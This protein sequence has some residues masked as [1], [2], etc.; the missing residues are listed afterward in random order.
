MSGA[1]VIRKS[2]LLSLMAYT[3]A[4]IVLSQTLQDP[5]AV[6]TASLGD[7]YK[8]V[9]SSARSS[10][11]GAVEHQPAAA[12]PASGHSR[13]G[14]IISSSNNDKQLPPAAGDVYHSVHI[15]RSSST[16]ALQQ[17]AAGPGPG[18]DEPAAQQQQQQQQQQQL[19]TI[20]DVYQGIYSSGHDTAAR[21]QQQQLNPL[22][23]Q[24]GSNAQR[25]QATMSDAYQGAYSTSCHTA[26][27]E[28]QQQELMRP[29]GS[30]DASQQQHVTI[31]DVHQGTHAVSGSKPAWSAQQSGGAAS[32]Q[33]GQASHRQY[34]SVGNVHN[35]IYS[36]ASGSRSSTSHMRQASLNALSHQQ[37]QQQGVHEASSSS[38]SSS[39]R[40]PRRQAAPAGGSKGKV[41]PYP[42]LDIAEIG[43]M[44]NN[45][46]QKILMLMA[47]HEMT[48]SRDTTHPL[49]FW[50]LA[51]LHGMPWAWRGHT[52]SSYDGFCRHYS[53][54][55]GPW[56][57]PYALAFEQGLRR[58]GAAAVARLTN[59]TLRHEYSRLLPALRLP[60]WDWTAP[61]VPA[62]LIA[63]SV[64]IIDPA[65]QPLA[66]Y[67]PFR[68]YTFPAKLGDRGAIGSRDVDWP[69][70]VA[71]ASRS[72]ATQ[73][74]AFVASQDWN[75]TYMPWVGSSQQSNGCAGNL[76]QMHN[77]IHETI[78]GLTGEMAIL[79]YG[80]FDPLF[81]LHHAMIDRALWLYQ[82]NKGGWQV[83]ANG[84]FSGYFSPFRNI[85]GNYESL[86]ATA[87][88]Y[89]DPVYL[90]TAAQPALPVS[91]SSSGSSGAFP[92]AADAGTEVDSAAA[93]AAVQRQLAAWSGG[94]KGYTW[95]LQLRQFRPTLAGLNQT[96]DVFVFIDGV[97]GAERF[98]SS[99]SSS[100]SRIRPNTLRL[101]KDYCGSATTWKGA[102]AMLAGKRFSLSVDLT[103]CMRAAGISADVA[104]AD[105][106]NAAKGPARAPIR[107]SDLRFMVL[108]AS[109]QDL[110]ADVNLGKPVIGWALAVDAGRQQ[111]LE[112]AS[113]QV[114]SAVDAIESAP[115]ALNDGVYSLHQGVFE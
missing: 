31:G 47:W 9:Y 85:T 79:K 21:Q 78:G 36:G 80:G 90:Q 54:A 11:N 84:D 55:F 49:S 69:A 103:S 24:G 106:S 57:R 50:A 14:A 107:V 87:Y 99:S 89:K 33:V 1:R 53:P 94:H 58:A 71:R 75:C 52:P 18:K 19:A 66:V 64:T 105:A 22:Q 45:S 98:P 63:D 3:L 111:Q 83:N 7:V 112:V 86:Q 13:R 77:I 100:S 101:R 102:A 5:Y 104:P 15:R 23:P 27:T 93:V 56:H 74:V 88:T 76:E 30:S 46:K 6:G 34:S 26:A 4:H 61:S 91:T 73:M 12:Q 97:L 8:G 42:R 96:V 67:N 2:T 108:S 44:P 114:G 38:S 70:A 10:M 51:G 37:G 60:Y 29:Q 72:R 32:S 62:I 81:W 115:D 25:Q 16:A 40:R 113:R 20:G 35:G 109:G 39:H 82:A 110:T 41:V 92:P 28:Q 43:A 95:R 48:S 68:E 65:G 59:T 17:P